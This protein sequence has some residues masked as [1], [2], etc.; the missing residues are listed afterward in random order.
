MVPEVGL[1]DKKLK[2]LSLIEARVVTSP[3][4]IVISFAHQSREVVEL[5]L[6]TFV[7]SPARVQ[8][9]DTNN[10]F[11]TA[12]AAH[13]LPVALIQEPSRYSLAVLK[14]LKQLVA[15]YQ[16]DIVQTNSVKSHFLISLLRNRPFGW[17][18]FHH[19]YTAED[20]KMRLYNQLDRFSLRA[21]D[22]VV[23]VCHP[24]ARQVQA[25]GVPPEKIRV[26]PNGIAADF[27]NVSDRRKVEWRNQFS[28]APEES[29]IFTAG[30]LSPEK[31][32]QY[33]IE[34]AAQLARSGGNL[35]W[36]ML[37]AGSGVLEKS[38]AAQIQAAGLQDSVKLVGHQPEV[39][40]LFGIADIFVLPS[41][42]EG[43]P[44]VLLESMAA[45]VPIVATNVGG[46]PEAVENGES[47]LLVPHSDSRAL[48]DALAR[49]LKDRDY[50]Q[51]LAESAFVRVRKNF[52]PAL[53][54]E[55]V[56]NAFES[57]LKQKRQAR[58]ER[59]QVSP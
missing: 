44:M 36:K 59:A 27:L 48:S 4:K 54:N 47:A 19:G 8:S 15:E 29:V 21:C 2:I 9:A 13:D 53:Y 12:A 7:R 52:S 50:A 39:K 42:S 34:A 58:F 5:K 10:P 31:G 45:E 3:A 28:I 57:V 35:R 25:V 46:I 26:I 37:I 38:L 43:S 33:L 17:V 32:H 16:P 6:V 41:L 49:L 18:A 30:R 14:D 40:P 55:R 22:L 1:R 51:R 24:F 56:L 20:A 23:T 11:L